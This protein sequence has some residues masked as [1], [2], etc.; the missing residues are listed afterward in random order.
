MI[1][2]A[3]L[4]A[5][6][7]HEK[8]LFLKHCKLS[9]QMRQLRK[10]S[11]FL[12]NEIHMKRGI[13]KRTKYKIKQELELPYGTILFEG[14]NILGPWNI[15]PGSYQCVLEDLMFDEFSHTNIEKVLNDAGHSF[16]RLTGIYYDPDVAVKEI[17]DATKFDELEWSLKDPDNDLATLELYR[18]EKI[19]YMLRAEEILGQGSTMFRNRYKKQIDKLQKDRK[20]YVKVCGL[21]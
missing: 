5:L 14:R 1:S 12:V 13:K 9:G 3:D 11:V 10:L 18:D 6:T 16:T 8:E 17:Q 19:S 21:A 4:T 20:R 2:I 7:P 15:F